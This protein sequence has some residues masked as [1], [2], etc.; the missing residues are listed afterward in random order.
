MTNKLI[1]QDE[2]MKMLGIGS[3]STLWVLRTKKG[4]P[5]PVLKYPM[6]FLRSEVEAWV[7]NGGI[8]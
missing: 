4:F 2:V 7:D 6:R 1:H 8:N 5:K 3:K